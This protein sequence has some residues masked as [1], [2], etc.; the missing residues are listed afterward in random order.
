MNRCGTWIVTFVLCSLLGALLPTDVLAQ[1]RPKLGLND[2]SWLWPVPTTHAELNNTLSMGS[3]NKPDGTPV[4]SDVQ[5]GSILD[6]VANGATE[7][8][9]SGVDFPSTFSNKANWRIAGMRIDPTAPGGHAPLRQVFG[10]AVQIRLII[11]PVTTNGATVTVHDTAVHLVYSFLKPKDPANPRAN[12]PD[13]EKF[14]EILDDV[15]WLKAVCKAG[16]VATDGPLG[17]HP[18]LAANVPGLTDELGRFLGK[19]LS[20]DKLTAMAVMGIEDGREPWIFLA[21]GPTDNGA[22]GPLAMD[23]PFAKPQMIDFR[24]SPG[25]VHP[26]PIVSNRPQPSSVSPT[27]VATNV[28]FGI[29]STDLQD[30]ATIGRDDSGAAIKDTEVKNSDI[31]DVV[32]NPILSNFFNTDCVSCHTESQR[33]SALGIPTGDFAFKVDN[34][35]PERSS[36]VTSSAIWNVH[37]FGWFPDFFRQGQTFPTASQR[38]ANETAEVLTF[39]EEHFDSQP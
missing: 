22:F 9:G 35:S 27:G 21:L 8:D 7:V 29:S 37:S 1:S 14:R 26:D 20:P 38:T 33:R 31:P 13:N 36:E 11:Q 28:L 10:S 6:T 12:V 25:T 23:M 32:A 24:S 34:Q 18:G 30:F 5:F 16:G 39:I 4:W 3:L 19:H 2:V 15:R 17:V